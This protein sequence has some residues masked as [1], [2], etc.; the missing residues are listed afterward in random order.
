MRAAPAVPVAQAEPARLSQQ[1][2]VK[3]QAPGQGSG[4]SLAPWDALPPEAEAGLMADEPPAMDMSADEAARMSVPPDDELSM[5]VSAPRDAAP[6][7]PK[8]VSIQLPPAGSDPLSDRWAALVAELNAKGL[9]TALVRELAMQAQCVGQQGSAW[10]LLVDRESLRSD[11]NRDRLA[12][13]MSQHLGHD[14][15]L[16]LDKGAAFNT[17]AQRDQVAREL[18]QQQAEQLIEGDA[19]V[20]NLLAQ[21]PGARIVPGSIRPL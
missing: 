16:T 3:R 10:Q 4:Q 2:P 17:P 8:A 7:G 1:E 15:V 14:V 11:A 21:Y 18:R 6:R 12:Q 9:I 19:L 20:Q 5:P 13:A